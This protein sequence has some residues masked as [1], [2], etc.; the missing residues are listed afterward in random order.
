[1]RLRSCVQGGKARQ[2]AENAGYLPE[3]SDEQ[4]GTIRQSHSAFSRRRMR[5]IQIFQLIERKKLH[6]EILPHI[7]TLMAIDEHVSQTRPWQDRA[8]PVAFDLH[9][10]SF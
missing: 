3:V 5:N 2:R 9:S 8:H 6:E 4:C 7:E 10:D 1:M